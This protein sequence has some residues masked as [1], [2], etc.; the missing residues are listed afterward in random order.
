MSSA[1]HPLQSAC[2]GGVDAPCTRT[3]SAIQMTRMTSASMDKSLVFAIAARAHRQVNHASKGTQMGVTLIAI[4]AGIVILASARRNYQIGTV[5]RAGTLMSV[6]T[7]T[8]VILL[9]S[10]LFVCGSTLS[11]LERRVEMTLCARA[12]MLTHV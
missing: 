3:K 11:T 1:P 2:R 7:V 5:A 8:V 6:L 4:L 10:R 12:T 9:W